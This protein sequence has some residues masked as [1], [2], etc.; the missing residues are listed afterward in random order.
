[1]TTRLCPQQ[2]ADGAPARA[3]KSTQAH[4][5][6]YRDVIPTGQWREVLHKWVGLPRKWDPPPAP[7]SPIRSVFLT[8]SSNVSM[9]TL[10]SEDSFPLD[11]AGRTHTRNHPA[12]CTHT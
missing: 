8:R 1:M 11:L 10:G 9:Q 5:R 12:A 2:S 3:H 7:L 6:P 4:A